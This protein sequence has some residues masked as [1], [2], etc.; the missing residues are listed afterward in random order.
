VIEQTKIGRIVIP[1]Q[2]PRGFTL[3]YT[4]ID[5]DGRLDEE[6][7][8]ALLEIAGAS[9][10]STCNQV[11]GADVARAG[12]ACDTCDALFT[13]EKSVALG[14]KVADCLPITMV[15]PVHSVIANIHS[16]WRG[17]VRRITSATLDALARD[18]AFEPAQARAFLGP[19]IRV[20]CFE[21]GEEVATQFPRQFVER[22]KAK[23]HV[24]I[25]AFTKDILQARGVEDIID[26]GLCTRC[27]GSIFH[28]FRRD[29]KTGGRNLAV[30]AH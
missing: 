20:C 4:T 17:A 19:S 6:R 13:D 12:R 28:S 18:T 3:F 24:D 14:I 2:V 7:T 1:P 11:H 5:I 15:D 27:D 9:T 22:S 30:I 26:T 29:G 8:R 21:V 25:V 16:G 10:L 23:P